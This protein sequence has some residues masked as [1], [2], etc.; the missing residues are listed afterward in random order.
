MNIRTNGVKTPFWPTKPAQA[1]SDMFPLLRKER[2]RVRLGNPVNPVHPVLKIVLNTRY[3]STEKG[4][5]PFSCAANDEVQV[6]CL[7]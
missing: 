7:K 3:P 5:K 6:V 2:G 4:R 1:G